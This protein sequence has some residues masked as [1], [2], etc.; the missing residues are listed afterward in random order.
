VSDTTARLKLRL[1]GARELQSVVRTMKSLAASSIG[2]YQTAVRALSDYSRAADLGLGACLR[3]RSLVSPVETIV[4]KR[5]VSIAL[6]A[7]GGRCG[8]ESACP[9]SS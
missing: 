7:I 3:E 2:Q 1:S 9:R 5:G 6:G 4:R 8:R